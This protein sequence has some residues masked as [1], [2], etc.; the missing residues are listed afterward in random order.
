MK[1][2]VTVAVATGEAYGL[3]PV[4]G[5]AAGRCLRMIEMLCTIVLWKR[6]GQCQ[7]VAAAWML[8]QTNVMR[9]FFA[10]FILLLAV[11]LVAW[12]VV[13]GLVFSF[14]HPWATQ[15]EQLLYMHKALRFEKVPYNEMRP[16]EP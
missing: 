14:R 11:L 16:R 10:K 9:E 1:C 5:T 2:G 12:F 7:A 4:A 3:V 13:A 8:N 15:T 6:S